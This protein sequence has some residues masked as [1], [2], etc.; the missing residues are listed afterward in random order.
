MNCLI[1]P[2]I[3]KCEE[4][5]TTRRAAVLQAAQG[6]QPDRIT[7]ILNDALQYADEFL[8]RPSQFLFNLAEMNNE[9]FFRLLRAEEA[10]KKKE[11]EEAGN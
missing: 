11:A 3:K 10:R 5:I 2:N 6:E 9:T 7:Q 8:T 1:C 4:I